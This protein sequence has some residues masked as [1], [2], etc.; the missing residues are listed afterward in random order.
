M[1]VCEAPFLDRGEE[2]DDGNFGYWYEGKH[3]TFTFEGARSIRCRIYTDTPNT[4]SLYFSP[5]GPFEDDDETRLAVDWLKQ[6]GI[7][8][9][10]VLGGSKG[11]YR[12]I[13]QQ[14]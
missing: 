10:K 1:Q 3:I 5:D 4:A 12:P 2:D 9:V 7:S 8:T 13:W 11:A 14:G 6:T